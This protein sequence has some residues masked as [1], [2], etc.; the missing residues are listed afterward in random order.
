MDKG[1]VPT[2][3]KIGFTAFS[4]VY[5]RYMT[6]DFPES[7]LKPLPVI[8]KAFAAGK[9]AAYILQEDNRTKAYASFLWDQE[10]ILL[11]DYFA[12]T[13]ESGRGA[14]IGSLFLQELARTITAKGFIIE[15]ELPEKAINEQE[16]I[17]REKRIAF[18]VRN[19]AEITTTR[20]T[21]FGVAFQILYMP[22]DKERKSI[23]VRKELLNI[24]QNISSDKLL[25]K[26]VKIA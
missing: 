8:E 21:V 7:E 1:A 18:Y 17:L 12:V 4:A 24:Y 13:Q 6:T 5:N 14:G 19:G 9:Y 3:R 25:Q 16:R 15:C 11:L 10:D 23:D 20:A 26:F 2:V 22:L